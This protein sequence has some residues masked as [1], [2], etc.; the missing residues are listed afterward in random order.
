MAIVRKTL[1]APGTYKAP[2]GSTT[3]TPDRI[4]GWV[5]KFRALKANGVQ[6]GVPWGHFRQASPDQKQFL[7]SRFNAG[8][9]EDMLVGPHGGLDV[10]LDCPGLREVGGKLVGTATLPDG[11]TVET[12]I[13]EVSAGIWPTWT[14]GRGQKH[15]DLIGHVALTTMPVVAGT[16][17]FV[18]LS[19][20]GGDEV[21]YLSTEAAMKSDDNDDG[22]GL[23]GEIKAVTDAA[24]AEPEPDVDSLLNPPAPEQNPAAERLTR[25]LG[26]LAEGGMSL[27]PDTTPENFLERLETAVGVLLQSLRE[28]KAT[29]AAQQSAAAVQTDPLV[30][31]SAPAPG[32]MLSTLVR[33]DDQSPMANFARQFVR[34]EVERRRERRTKR[35]ADL[36][37]RGLPVA[38]A[39]KLSGAKIFL[40]TFIDPA[41]GETR[42]D[43]TDRAIELLEQSLP[44][45]DFAAVMLS[46][47]P[48]DSGRIRGHRFNRLPAGR[49][50]VLGD[51]DEATYVQL[52]NPLVA[53]P[54]TGR[55]NQRGEFH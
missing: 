12:A 4:S 24:E 20:G 21:I 28:Q 46:G 1:L 48:Q 15:D 50:M 53:E 6:F 49:A 42:D 16:G 5:D 34:G 47:N 7:S 13:K 51:S 22:K 35:I 27:P 30:E 36:K 3:I 44:S 14:D 10:V 9:I 45:A 26:M 40:S 2:A 38:V 11:S 54:L 43:E 23:D 55:P 17:D 8:Y 25:V 37:A 39:D 19:A 32:M 41:T 33:S 18:G 29:A 31:E 52:I